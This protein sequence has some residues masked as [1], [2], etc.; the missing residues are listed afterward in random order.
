VIRNLAL[1]CWAAAVCQ[2]SSLP[3][4]CTG[5]ASLG[6][7]QI[8]VRPFSAGAPLPLK[9]VAEIPGGA[10]LIWNPI[11]LLP[12]ASESAEDTAVLVPASDG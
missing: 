12:P 10:R 1:C 7:I 11:H 6:T 3:P 8:S 2:A 9:S 4:G 5:S